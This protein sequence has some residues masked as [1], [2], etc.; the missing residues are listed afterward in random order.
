MYKKLFVIFGA[1][2]ILL[3]GCLPFDNLKKDPVV[4]EKDNDNE[5]AI[6]LQNINTTDD[7][8]YKSLKNY[9]PG[10]ARGEISYGVDN[11][12]DVDEMETGLMR[13]SKDTFAIDDYYFQEGQYL[14]KDTIRNW[15]K[16]SSQKADKAKGGF[17]QKGLNPGIDEEAYEK[18]SVDDKKEMLNNDPKILSYVLEQNYLK[19]SG[20]DSVELG[21]ISV[22]LAFNSKYYYKVI[23]EKG[24]IHPGEKKLDAKDVKKY[25]SKAGQEV[26]NR[27]RQHPELQDVPIVIGLFYEEEHGAVV[28]GNYFG[29]AVVKPGSTNVNWEDVNEKYY[30]FPSAKAEEDHRED[31]NK[32]VQFEGKIKE[33]FP[34][35]IGVIG[36]ALYRNDQIS[37]LTI[38]IPMQF[39]GKSEVISFTQY[40]NYLV[41]QYFPDEVVE[42]NIKS[43]LDELESLIVTDPTKDDSIVHIY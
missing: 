31:F 16:R 12:I 19:D 13:L 17:I 36:K 42:V 7:N 29:K 6:P 10:A 5:K 39:K 11:R 14:T 24:R 38:E 37:K 22:A 35:Y 27:L 4:E 43:S 33:Y 40:V 26:V 28:P 21:G 18:G 9:E 15:L 34:N 23:D 20:K 8:Y 32:F 3:S 25:A 41:K 30:F 1:S 2:L